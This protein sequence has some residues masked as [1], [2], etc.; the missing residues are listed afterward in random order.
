MPKIKNWSRDEDAPYARWVH[1]ETGD[2]IEIGPADQTSYDGYG[3][4]KKYQ[5]TLWSRDGLNN[6]VISSYYSSQKDAMD[7][8]KRI[9]RRNPKGKLVKSQNEKFHYLE[10]GEGDPEV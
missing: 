1:D 7:E 3:T 5:V 4:P 10:W 6:R 9:A 2:T 8:A